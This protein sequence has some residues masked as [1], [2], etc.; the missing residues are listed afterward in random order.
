MR[1][2]L[3]REPFHSTLLMSFIIMIPSQVD[4]FYI[5]HDVSVCRARDAENIS[6]LASAAIDIFGKIMDVT[7]RLERWVEK[8]LHRPPPAQERTWDANLFTK[9]V[10]ATSFFF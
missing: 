3:F 4:N 9:R 2:N 8:L 5:F 1:G 7:R 6:R 10:E